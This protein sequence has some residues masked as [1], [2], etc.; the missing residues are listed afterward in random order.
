MKK[1]GGCHREDIKEMAFLLLRFAAEGAFPPSPGP[2]ATP[3]PSGFALKRGTALK[4]R[5]CA[6]EAGGGVQSS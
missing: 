6:G 5:V 4:G 2:P 1:E 3:F